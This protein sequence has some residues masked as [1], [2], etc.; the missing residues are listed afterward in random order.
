M[1]AP[2]SRVRWRWTFCLIS[3]PTIICYFFSGQRIFFKPAWSNYSCR[4]RSSRNLTESVSEA[5][6]WDLKFL[7]LCARVR[8][9]LKLHEQD[10]SQGILSGHWENFLVVNFGIRTFLSPSIF[11]KEIIF[12]KTFI[13]TEKVGFFHKNLFFPLFQDLIWKIIYIA[14]LYMHERSMFSRGKIRGSRK[15]GD[16]K[17]RTT[18]TIIKISY[19]NL[20]Q[21]CIPCAKL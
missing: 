5:E 16:V 6:A 19:Q 20:M 11:V 10:L 13:A 17:L 15:K 2:T 1:T 7:F 18:Q 21:T 14:K 4:S 12:E 3:L 9:R 8:V